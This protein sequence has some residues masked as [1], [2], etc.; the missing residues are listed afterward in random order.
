MAP[1]ETRRVDRAMSKG[2]PVMQGIDTSTLLFR[3]S[4]RAEGPSARPMN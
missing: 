4:G 3:V 1:D 2:D